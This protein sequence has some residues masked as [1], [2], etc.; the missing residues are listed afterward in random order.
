M[1]SRH[2]EPAL[3]PTKE[4]ISIIM[5]FRITQRDRLDIL[6]AT[7]RNLDA[8]LGDTGI[9]LRVIDASDNG[10]PQAVRNAL[11]TLQLPVTYIHKCLPLAEAY[12]HLLETSP[13][14]YIY[15]QFDDQITTNLTEEFLRGSCGLMERY[16]GTV[17]VVAPPWPLDVSV[18]LARRTLD[19]H[20]FNIKESWPG[21]QSSRRYMFGNNATRRPLAIRTFNEHEFGIFRNFHYGFFFNHL[22]APAPDFL[23]RL[24][25]YRR[26]LRTNSAHQIELAASKGTLGP[27]WRVIGASL[28]DVAILDLD[29]VH[30]SA[31][32]RPESPHIKERLIALERGFRL[33]AFHRYT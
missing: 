31:A 24:K 20:T 11:E 2:L 14:P 13:T 19:V 4:L 6:L 26:N 9:N 18:K 5:S 33:S 27:A 32:V 15:L 12:E 1:P 25:W 23:R 30:T 16:R 3:P 21:P 7:L 8:A 17:N 22:I 10:Y 28:K 29:Y